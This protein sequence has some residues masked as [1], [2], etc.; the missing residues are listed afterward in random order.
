MLPEENKVSLI[1]ES[2]ALSSFKL[3]II[4]EKRGQE[5]SDGMSQTSAEVIKNQFRTMA[6]VAA[7]ILQETIL[8]EN[9]ECLGCPLNSLRMVK[10]RC[11]INTLEFNK[12]F[13]TGL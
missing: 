5:T 6:S 7:M 12:R 1:M 11:N 9:N 13:Q 8:R 4:R 2:D 3:R 10:T